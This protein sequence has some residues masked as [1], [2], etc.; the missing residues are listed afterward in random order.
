[1]HAVKGSKIQV[2]P[3]SLNESEFQFLDDLRIYIEHEQKRLTDDGV[4][5]FLLRNES[6]GRGVGFFQAGNFYPDFLLWQVKDGVQY[7]SFVEPHGLQHE[8]PGHKKIEF[9]RTIKAIE[10]RL[11]DEDVVLNSFVVTPTRYGQLNWGKTIDEL[12]DM[13][14]LF[15]VDQADTYVSK[16][17][18]RMLY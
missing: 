17:V 1:M 2:T 8:G 7:L 18:E 5:I 11:G 15:M 3:V 12:E 6:R 9:H 4:E 10:D 14:V 16:I 13:N